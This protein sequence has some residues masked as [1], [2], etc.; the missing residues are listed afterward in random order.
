M[1]MHSSPRPGFAAGSH[2]KKMSVPLLSR[3]IRKAANH[4]APSH[5]R[6]P[7]ADKP[8]PVRPHRE[9]RLRP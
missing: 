9:A 4:T 1:A 5:P 3:L 2:Q 6:I 8:T 7:P